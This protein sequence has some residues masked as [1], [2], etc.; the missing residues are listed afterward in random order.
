[1]AIIKTNLTHGTTGNLPAVNGSAVTALNASNVAS[2]TL[3]TARYVQ[4]GITMAQQWRVSAAY[5]GDNSPITS[6]WEISDDPSHTS[7][8]SNMTQSS[9]IFTF[10]STGIYHVEFDALVYHNAV[11][12]ANVVEI[13]F[14]QNNSSYQTVAMGA[15][16]VNPSSADAAGNG[17]AY[18]GCRALLDV[19]NVSTHKVRFDAFTAGD[20]NAAWNFDTNIQSGGVTFMRIGDT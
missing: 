17:G 20:P 14:T 5:S 18:M 7:L 6:N 10:P 4:G 11:T 15:A 1:M 3:A 16:T 12:A 9:G 13:A 2:G 8:G 19:T